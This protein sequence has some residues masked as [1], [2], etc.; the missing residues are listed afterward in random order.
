MF[1]N[2]PEMFGNADNLDEQSRIPFACRSLLV[3][4]QSL[5]FSLKLVRCFLLIQNG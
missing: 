2:A 3:Q 1:G 5:M 4:T